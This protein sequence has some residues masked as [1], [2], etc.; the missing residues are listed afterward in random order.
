MN[1]TIELLDRYKGAKGAASDTEVA[2]MLRVTKAAVSNWRNG[3]SKPEAETVA[4]MCH[5]TGEK[6][7]HWLPLIEADRARSAESRKVWLRLAA[8]AA[9]IAL[10]ALPYAVGATQQWAES[11]AH[12][13]YIM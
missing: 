9:V 8:Q 1:A 13:M 5:A 11:T 7:A 2:K 4:A 12:Q 10:V 6:L 3:R